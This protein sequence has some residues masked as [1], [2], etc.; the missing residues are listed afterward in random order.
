MRLSLLEYISRQSVGSEHNIKSK[1]SFTLP[2]NI[3]LRISS[4]SAQQKLSASVSISQQLLHLHHPIIATQLLLDHCCWTFPS[5]SQ[6]SWFKEPRSSKEC[7]SNLLGLLQLKKLSISELVLS[8]IMSVTF[9]TLDYSE[10]HKYLLWFHVLTLMLS[11]IIYLY[12][13]LYL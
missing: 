3:S 12:L 9:V 6:S 4:T 8:I 13:Y 5:E 10:K 7:D 2:S 1:H 11:C